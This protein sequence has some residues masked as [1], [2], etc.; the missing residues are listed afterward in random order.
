MQKFS[1]L[2]MLKDLQTSHLNDSELEQL[3]PTA[4]MDHLQTCEQFWAIFVNLLTIL[5][6]TAGLLRDQNVVAIFTAIMNHRAIVLS[7][8][9]TATGSI[10][11]TR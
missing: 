2:E 8:L 7:F 10:F 11:C 4:L 9:S 1:I 5:N 3:A 6:R